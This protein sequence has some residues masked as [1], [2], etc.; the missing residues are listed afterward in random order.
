M[1]K[2][3][4]EVS[5]PDTHLS[6]RL[7]QVR[8]SRQGEE[9]GRFPAEDVG[10]LIVDSPT[11]VYTHSTLVELVAQGAVVLLCGPDHLPAAFVTPCVANSVQTE[12]LAAQVNATL[13][14][15]KRLW[16]QIVQA[17]IRNQARLLDGAPDIQRQLSALAARVRSGDPENLEARAARLY[18]SA[19]LPDR[20]FHRKRHGEPPNNLL[21]YGYAVLRAA[22]ARALAGAGLHPSIALHH[23]NRYDAFCLADDLMEPLRPAVDRLARELFLA[24][25]EDLDRDAKKGLLAVLVEPVRMAN[26]EKGPL[27]VEIEKMAASLARCYAGEAER[28]TIPML[29]SA[30]ESAL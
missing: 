1:I 30:D 5:G 27:L 17:K 24:G 18:W 26:K 20:I 11:A 21:N 15:R 10:L 16:R 19:W 12:R 6:V 25:S 14:L 9:I 4:I 22:V 29:E 28:L 13:P 3:T 8:V 7:G 23:H 2:R